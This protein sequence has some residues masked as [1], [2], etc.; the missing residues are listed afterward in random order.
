[1]TY[2]FPEVIDSTILNAFRSCEKKAQYEFF[3]NLASPRLSVHLHFGGAVAAG[4]E[5]A[6]RSF[7]LLGR[8]HA[9]AVTDALNAAWA[10]YGNFDFDEGFDE[11]SIFSRAKNYI[12]LLQ[13]LEGYF[14]EWPLG[15]CGLTPYNGR[16]GIEFSFALPIDGTK[17]PETGD[18]I[19]YAGRFDLLGEWQGL[20]TICDEKTASSFGEN[21]AAQFDLRSQFLGYTWAC[22]TFGIPVEQILVRGIAILKTD[23]RYLQVIKHYPTYLIDRW[24]RQT[25]HDLNRMAAAYETGQFNFNLGDACSSFGGCS[26]TELCKSRDP[27]E[28]FSMFVERNWS[29]L[30]KNPEGEK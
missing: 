23:I 8:P 26:F 18:P 27:K 20:P 16:E 28:W 21:W 24:H 7:F 4:V 30:R 22:R 25:V 17:H 13:G 6:R 2:R 1:M 29:P 5:A 10:Y 9:E 14:R 15:E 12:S 19:V 11:I 3:H